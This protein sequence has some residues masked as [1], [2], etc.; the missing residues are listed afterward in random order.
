MLLI[1]SK[2]ANSKETFSMI[3]INKTCPYNEVIYDI[4]SKLLIVLSKDKKENL[5]TITKMLP[6]NINTTV[7]LANITNEETILLEQY[8]T[9][10][11][12][13]EEEIKNFIQRFGTNRESF[14]LDKYFK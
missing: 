5:T 9:Y 3:P 6:T 8:Y 7:G 14:N 4:D 11:I 1:T 12:E 13:K 2:D 10:H